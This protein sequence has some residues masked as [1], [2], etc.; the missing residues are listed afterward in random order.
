MTAEERDA[1]FIY[2]CLKCRDSGVIVVPHLE[3]LDDS[4][5]MRRGITAAVRCSCPAGD[6]H[7]N[8]RTLA[9]HAES[10]G[11]I[12]LVETLREWESRQKSA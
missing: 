8:L 5:R 9:I 10:L 2:R 1:V 12:D 7:K 11:C 6:R 3:S 4:G